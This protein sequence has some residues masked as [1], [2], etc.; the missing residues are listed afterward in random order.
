[1]TYRMFKERSNAADA[2]AK[3][4]LSPPYLCIPWT[5]PTPPALPARSNPPPR[6]DGSSS[7]FL[8]AV[9]PNPPLDCPVC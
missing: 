1:M 7:A 2:L 8:R 9:P 6:K 4:L 5:G 3:S